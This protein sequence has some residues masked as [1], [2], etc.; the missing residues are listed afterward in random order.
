MILTV[1]HPFDAHAAGDR[2]TGDAAAAAL[3]SHSAHVVAL[4]DAPVTAPE[5]TAPR[6]FFPDTKQPIVSDIDPS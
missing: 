5:P 1:I 4:A 3:A 2:L 6:Q